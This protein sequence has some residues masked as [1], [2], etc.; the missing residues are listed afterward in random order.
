[1]GW[2]GE[3][4]RRLGLLLCCDKDKWPFVASIYVFFF[5]SFFFKKKK[6]L[7]N[8][9]YHVWLGLGLENEAGQFDGGSMKED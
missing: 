6:S 8:N 5:F 7:S 3:Y 4:E 9:S 2:R 1:M